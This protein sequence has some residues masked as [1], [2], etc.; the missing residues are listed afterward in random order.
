MEERVETLRRQ[1]GDLLDSLGLRP[2]TRRW[3]GSL[4]DRGLK[5]S[6]ELE[7]LIGPLPGKRILEIGSAYAG[8][9]IAMRAR[10]ADCVATDKFDFHYAEYPRRMN[11]LR[12]CDG[13]SGSF[14]IVRCD[15]FKRWPFPDASFDVVM[16]MELVEMVEDLDAFFAE[17]ARVL[18]PGG[19]ALLNTGVALR[20]IRRDPI[21]GLPL[22]AALP[23][24]LRRFVAEKIFRRGSDF[25]L[26]NHN[27]NS[28]YKFARHARP[29]G[30]DVR[31]V[32]FA[33]SP[34][35]ARLARWPFARLWTWFVRYFAFDFVFIVER[36]RAGRLAP[37]EPETID[38]RNA[39]SY[40]EMACLNL[41]P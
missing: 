3:V 20:S 29:V 7:A 23:N 12:T 24:R 28:A 35:M 38:S 17:V 9:L 22:I 1:Y 18:R 13:E 5:L 6:D 36:P 2:A 39:T 30:Y 19:V 8:D 41:T 10:G 14:H 37:S 40:H 25:R 11:A 33:G 4:Y 21:Y 26:S 31:P 16:A 32:K 15:A 27:F 34:L